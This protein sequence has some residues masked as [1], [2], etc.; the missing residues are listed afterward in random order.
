MTHSLI[1]NSIIILICISLSATQKTKIIEALPDNEADTNVDVTK[2]SSESCPENE[3]W[4]Y[5]KIDDRSEIFPSW[6]T[7]NDFYFNPISRN[8]F[9]PVSSHLYEDFEP[10]SAS[11]DGSINVL[12]SRIPPVRYLP[13]VY[14][15]LHNKFLSQKVE[16][17]EDHINE[18]VRPPRVYRSEDDFWEQIK[19]DSIMKNIL[20]TMPIPFFRN[21]EAYAP[22]ASN[23]YY[24]P[25]VL[26]CS[27]GIINEE[28]LE[29]DSQKGEYI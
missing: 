1:L 19:R 23:L 3:N 10:S 4:S 16:S 7:T 13:P 8:Y 18:N 14:S 11:F 6:L 12:K 28:T 2:T 9:K 25:M 27:H 5:K 24:I 15:P 29:N 20:P 26:V 22:E 21:I 17:D